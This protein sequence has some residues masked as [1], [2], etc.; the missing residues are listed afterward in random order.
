MI[1]AF[2]S[3]LAFLTTPTPPCTCKAP[4]VDVVDSVVVLTN[5]FPDVVRISR[6][7]FPLEMPNQRLAAV[8]RI[9]MS[10]MTPFAKN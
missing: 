1:V 8:F 3:M 6:F 9:I 2:P 7:E 10:F 5:I 4:V